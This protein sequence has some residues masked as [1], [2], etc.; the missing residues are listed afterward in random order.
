MKTATVTAKGTTLCR[1]CKENPADPHVFVAGACRTCS[2]ALFRVFLA[3]AGRDP[4]T[5]DPAAT[6][7]PGAWAQ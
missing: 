5:G 1:H 2:K 3:Q 4:D 6:P 7:D